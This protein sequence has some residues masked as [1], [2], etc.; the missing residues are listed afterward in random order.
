MAGGAAN[1]ALTLCQRVK[2]CSSRRTC[3]DRGVGKE[4]GRQRFVAGVLRVT[5]PGARRRLLPAKYGR[6]D[7]AVPRSVSVSPAGATGASRTRSTDAWPMIRTPSVSSLTSAIVRVHPDAAGA[8]QKGG[9]AKEAKHRGAVAAGSARRCAYGG[10]L[11]Q[12]LRFILTGGQQDYIILAE[13]WR[14][15]RATRGSM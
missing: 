13:A 5:R 9:A 11:G 12:P 15:W 7:P 8:A 14:G 2:V 1:L 6:R 4:D 3:S 10:R